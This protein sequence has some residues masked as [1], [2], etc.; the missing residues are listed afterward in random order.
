MQEFCGCEGGK[1]G[2]GVMA[3][4]AQKM[5]AAPKIP[6]LII[7]ECE[8]NSPQWFEARLGKVTA[9]NFADVMAGGEGKTRTRYLRDLAGE[10]ITGKPKESYSNK[11]ME[12]GNAMEDQAREQYERT[13]FADLTRV[14]FVYNPA[15]NAGC[16]PDA[17]IG[18]DGILEIK[19]MIPALL[20]GVLERGT[21]PQ[22]HRAQ[23]HGA[24]WV[25][26]RKF[27]VLRIFYPGMPSFEATIEHDPIYEQE[28][29][30]AVE[31]FNY[32]LKKLVE[33]LKAMMR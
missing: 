20:I 24:M 19:T 5:V 3:K 29:S 30:N 27:C 14:G 6:E 33:K 26:R 4:A 11:S 21:M 18:D 25:L 23:C 28:I 8:Q 7:H 1:E 15:I 22:E 13:K 31:I 17:L 32:D 10:I 16:S 9:S 2:E 12:R